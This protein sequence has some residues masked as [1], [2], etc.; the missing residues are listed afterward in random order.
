M[1][2]KWATPNWAEAETVELGAGLKPGA[3][4]AVIKGVKD[5]PSNEQLAIDFDIAEGPEAGK[6]AGLPEN[7]KWMA[8]F[9]QGYSEKAKAF[10]QNFIVAVQQSNP[11]FVF[12]NDEK[13]LVG[14]LM[15]I[16]CQTE[17]YTANDGDETDRDTVRVVDVIAA[18]DVRAGDFKLP[19]IKD[20]RDEKW[21]AYEFERGKKRAA[22][23]P[24][25][26]AAGAYDEEIPF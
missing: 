14:K 16:V 24:A 4:V 11:G 1:K 13:A 2:F 26:A 22:A 7:R 18:Q 10:F 17:Y 23:Q 5:N 3:Y 20:R 12:A 8:R 6:F 25:P 21:R 9:N 15:G 19:D